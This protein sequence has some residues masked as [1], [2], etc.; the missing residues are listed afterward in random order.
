MGDDTTALTFLV[1]MAQHADAA[2]D[3]PVTGSIAATCA[4]FFAGEFTAATTIVQRPRPGAH[5]Y[6]ARS[7]PG[8]GQL[9]GRSRRVAQPPQLV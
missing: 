7:L 1:W 6:F 5:P 4:A 3:S 9:Q 2:D 8:D